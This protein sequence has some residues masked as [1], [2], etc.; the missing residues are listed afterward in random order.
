MRV[1]LK[2]W[3]G[4][5][6]KRDLRK[7]SSVYMGSGNSLHFILETVNKMGFLECRIKNLR[8]F[9]LKKSFFVK[10]CEF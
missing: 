5:V 3:V 7:G 8:E 9:W 1:C 4:S 10:N 2:Q 6:L